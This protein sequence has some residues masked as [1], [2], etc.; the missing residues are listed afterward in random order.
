MIPKVDVL[1]IR[2]NSLEQAYSLDT[3]GGPGG[4]KSISERWPG[5]PTVDFFTPAATSGRRRTVRF[6]SGLKGGAGG[7]A[8]CPWGWNCMSTASCPL[9]GGGI[10]YASRDG[11]FGMIND[12]DEDVLLSPKVIPIY[13]ANDEGFLLS[14]D[15]S[16]IQFA[17]EKRGQSPALF[18]VNQRQLTDASS[19]LWAGLKA[20]FTF[21]APITDGLGITDWKISFAPKLKGR[22]L[23]LK[24][25]VAQSLAIQPDR[26][27]F[28]LGTNNALWLFNPSGSVQWRIRTPAIVWGVNTN[29]QVATTA[30]GDGTIRWYRL[31]DGEEILA[32]FPHPDRKRWILWTPSGYYDASPGGEDFI[33]WHVNNGP[34]QAADFF[35][36]S[37]FRATYFR[38][39]VI[40]RV[41]VTMNEAEAIRLA[42]E[43]SGR[44]PAA[45]SVREKLPPVVT[46]LSPADGT[47]VAGPSVTIRYAVRGQEPRHCPQ[48]ARRRATGR[49]GRSRQ[50]GRGEGRGRHHDSPE[51][52]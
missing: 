21:Q 30:L 44:K 23:Q 48:G 2:D 50:V 9:E 46:I 32:F 4:R 14:P 51:R 27:G 8:T 39:D 24:Q 13:A 7:T 28:L 10:V 45:L 47:E 17:Y 52:L 35:P 6:A 37:R 5:H 31:S 11:S 43:E 38:P 1:A 22:P 20:G 42:N 41:L 12:R 26:T 18:S 29:G 15:G 19:N 34:D 36:V 25:E 3:I 49:R 33:G 16:A 40:D